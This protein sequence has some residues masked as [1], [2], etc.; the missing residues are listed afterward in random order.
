MSAKDMLPLG[1]VRTESGEVVVPA[2]RRADGSVRKPIRIRQGYVP[3]DETPKYKT[4]AQRRREQEALEASRHSSDV[5][6]ALQS[7]S[8]EAERKPPAATATK[9]AAPAA[10]GAKS[11]PDNAARK[12]ELSKLNKLLKDIS[13]LEARGGGKEELT[14]A[15]QRK[16]E[17]KAALQAERTA[18]IAALNGATIVS[19]SPSP[20]SQA[21]G[22]QAAAATSKKHFV[23]IEM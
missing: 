22:P 20:A 8:L 4:V 14:P 2:S 11:Q 16:L 13:K 6:T 9:T 12:Q 3:Q 15:Q 23:A 1:A 5:E 21:Q 18:I 19:S 7:L 10:P 17:R